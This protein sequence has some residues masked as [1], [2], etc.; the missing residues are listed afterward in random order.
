[1]CIIIDTNTFASVFNPES[2]HHGEFEPVFDWIINRKGKIVYGGSTYKAE[3]SKGYRYLKLFGSF[4]KAR[5]VV[6]IDDDLVDQYEEKLTDKVKHR[7]FDDPHLVAIAYISKCR[8]ICTNEKRAIPFLGRKEFYPK[9]SPRPKIYSKRSNANLLCDKYFAEVCN[10]CV[11]LNKMAA[12]SLV[13]AS[14]EI[15]K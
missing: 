13:R 14:Q 12:G 10:P 9:N 15:P 3:L 11:K 5:K 7:D 6:H 4:S 1:M 8:L 2:E